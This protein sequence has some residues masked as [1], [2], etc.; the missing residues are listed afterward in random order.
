MNPATITI[1]LFVRNG[2]AHLAGTI[3]S[4]LEQS[5]GDFELVIY[6]NASTDDTPTIARNHM[7]RDRRVRLVRRTRDIGAVANLIK[8][9][10]EARTPYFCWAAHDDLREPAFLQTLIGLLELHPDAALAC[11]AVQNIDPDGT[12]RDIRPETRSLRTTD[13]MTSVHRL[14]MYLKHAPGTPFYGL[15]RTATL[16]ESL[17][18]LRDAKAVAGPPMLGLDMAF[19]ANVLAR[20]GLAITH[21]P[22]LLF[23]RGGYSHRLEVYGSLRGLLAQIRRFARSLRSA[24][25]VPNQKMLER[26]RLAAARCSYLLRFLLS[27]PMR[28]MM[29]HYLSAALPKLR[30]MTAHW[31][32]KNHPA[33]ARLRRRARALPRDSRIVLFGAGRHTQRCFDAIRIAVAPRA[34][35]IGICD[36]AADGRSPIG[37][38]TPVNSA[39]IQSLN[40]DVVL[41]SSDAYEAALC[42]RAMSVV[43]RDSAIWCIYD[44]ELEAVANDRSDRS[45]EAMNS[46]ID[47][48]ASGSAR[49]RKGLATPPTGAALMASINEMR[50]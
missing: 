35:I 8:A 42:Q 17:W 13:G 19:L 28:R 44:L 24:T 45:T 20:H 36:D 39:H 30:W 47:S 4:L 23:R 9:A 29:L 18:V 22:L 48:S 31:S 3:E 21:E 40:P 43:P 11:C 34:S 46:S 33:F 10:E 37:A 2:A 7:E 32:A 38:H 15:F 16:Q 41:V 1:G 12:R 14:V 26:L 27:P 6:D 25:S 50:R 49:S 5:F